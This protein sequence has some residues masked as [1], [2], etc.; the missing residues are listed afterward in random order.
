LPRRLGLILALLLLAACSSKVGYW[1]TTPEHVRNQLAAADRLMAR[2]DAAGARAGYDRAAGS[3]HPEALIRAGRAWLA[4]PDPD[5]ARARDLFEAAW[6]RNS[7]RRDQAGVLLART[8]A[9]EEPDR[10]ITI[11]ETVAGRGEPRA[12]GELATL[13]MQQQPEDPRIEGLLRRAGAENDVNAL[14]TLA[15]D[16]QDEEAA[17]RAAQILESRHAA[18]DAFAANHIARLHAADGPLPDAALELVWLERAAERGHPAAMLGYGRALVRGDGVPPDPVQ[19]MA[20][21]R[22]SAEADNHWAQLELGR[23]LARGDGVE[24]DVEEGRMWLEKAAAQGNET[25]QRTL[26]GL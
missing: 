14:M 10:A 22:R 24:R 2:G 21:V 6:S 26:D 17:L 19:G 7:A 3:G 20:W 25:A 23:R 5:S 15:R 4:E 12:A 13:L 1:G 8:I 18:G 11:L 16:Y 9:A